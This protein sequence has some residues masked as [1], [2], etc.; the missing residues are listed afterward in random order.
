MFFENLLRIC[1]FP[2]P[3]AASAFTAS[4]Q[5]EQAFRACR[6]ER[7][8]FCPPAGIIKMTKNACKFLAHL[9]NAVCYSLLIGYSNK[10][11]LEERENV[12]NCPKY[13]PAALV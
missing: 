2:F 6:I 10:Y 5:S 7:G 1:I 8:R 4:T 11:C 12:G 13:F 9:Q 3:S